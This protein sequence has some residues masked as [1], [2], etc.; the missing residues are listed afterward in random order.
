M[1]VALATLGCKVNQY[2][3]EALAALFRRAGFEVV[4]FEE[5]ADVYVVNTCTVTQTGDKKSRQMLRRAVTRN[6]DA[7]VVATGC[8]AQS[9][10]RELQAIPGVRVV[11][12]TTPRRGV[13]DAVLRALEQ[14]GQ[15]VET[16]DARACREY[17]ELQVEGS[18]ERA[19]AFVKIEDGCDSFCSYCR[20]PYVRGPVRSR[21]PDN[22]RDEVSR[23]AQ[24]GFREVVLTGIHLGFYGRDFGGRPDLADIVVLVAGIPGIARVRLSSIDPTDVTDRLLD[25]MAESAKVCAHLHVPLQSGSDRVLSLMNRRY[26]V[27]E[28]E[29][30]VRSARERIPDL[31]LTTD[32]IVGFPGEDEEAFSSTFSAVER[33]RFSRLHVF[34]FSRRRGTAAW[35]MP[36]QVPRAEKERRSSALIKL[37]RRLALEFHQS[38]VGRAVDILVEQAEGG[39]Y[40]GLT[41]NYVRAVVRGTSRP[42]DLVKVR[43]TEARDDSVVATEEG[44]S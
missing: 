35:D 26:T 27:S 29:E 31:G 12:G 22:V 7:V 39:S 36:G 5:S 44:S 24:A 32:V 1:K 15:V 37:G 11:T 43:V 9:A 16:I 14:H 19:R 17:E 13:V 40:E 4:P 38:M 10:P 3:S 42:G 23:L 20:V 21:D 8:Y 6:P 25:V 18:A 30:V 28:Y 41:S 34:Q 33:I 2:D